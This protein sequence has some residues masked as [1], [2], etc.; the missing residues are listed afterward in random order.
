[1]NVKVKTVPALL[2]KIGVLLKGSKGIVSKEHIERL[3]RERNYS[4]EKINRLGW[5]ARTGMRKAVASMI[6]EL[7]SV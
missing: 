6:A 5:K 3:V 7:H 2:A 1:M 4:T